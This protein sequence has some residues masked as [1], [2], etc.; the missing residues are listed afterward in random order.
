MIR[1]A[2]R[3]AAHKRRKRHLTI[4]TK[5]LEDEQERVGKK[6]QI[7]SF[8]MLLL[9]SD[10]GKTKRGM[11]NKKTGPQKFSD[12]RDSNK[13]FQ[14]GRKKYM[15]EGHRGII[16]PEAEKRRRLAEKGR[17]YFIISNYFDNSKSKGDR[18]NIRFEFSKKTKHSSS[19]SK[20]KALEMLYDEM[21]VLENENGQPQKQRKGNER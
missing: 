7:V 12:K 1:S 19:K 18:K 10:S 13:V 15:F 17:I 3:T 21:T 11:K 6:L 5:A 8:Q 14:E 16:V 2:T 9:T 20:R 4:E